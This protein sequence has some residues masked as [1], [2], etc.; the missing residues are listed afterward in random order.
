MRTL[1]KEGIKSSSL[2]VKDL[3]E[4]P[5]TV[6]SDLK[7]IPVRRMRQVLD[8]AFDTAA[9]TDTASKKSPSML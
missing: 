6:K 4:V 9:F 5:H 7:I 8:A 3:Q 2:N 1:D